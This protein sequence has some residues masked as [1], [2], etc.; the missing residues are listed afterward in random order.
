MLFLIALKCSL[1]KK[2]SVC[3]LNFD[4]F[5]VLLLSRPLRLKVRGKKQN[6]LVR[7]LFMVHYAHIVYCM[8]I[9]LIVAIRGY[10]C[11]MFITN[12]CNVFVQKTSSI[13]GTERSII[14]ANPKYGCCAGGLNVGQSQ[15][16]MRAIMCVLSVYTK[17]YHDHT[18]S[19]R[20]CLCNDEF[21]DNCTS[22][23]YLYLV[24]S[25][26]T[27]AQTNIY[28]NAHDKAVK[29]SEIE[30]ASPSIWQDDVVFTA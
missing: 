27:T 24:I 11:V 15:R 13:F 22:T 18:Y 2:N 1:C 20:I 14:A 19:N 8:I 28:A 30:R 25:S 6:R 9:C 23:R 10:M 16:E 17:S 12:I 21:L 29:Q 5:Y 3:T 4:D 26:S 7:S